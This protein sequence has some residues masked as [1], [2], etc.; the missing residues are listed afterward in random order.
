MSKLSILKRLKL[1]IASIGWKLF[2]WGNETNKD[3]YWAEISEPDAIDFAEWVNLMDI[4]QNNNGVWVKNNP[5]FREN[6][7]AESTYEL[8]QIFKKINE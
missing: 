3:D 6:N 2:M 7:Y 8:Y 4:C 5:A 1:A